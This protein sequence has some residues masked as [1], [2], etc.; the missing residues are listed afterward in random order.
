M[1]EYPQ[2]ITSAEITAAI[3]DKFLEGDTAA[4]HAE[5]AA[6]VAA[7]SS[8]TRTVLA[9]ALREHKT[10]EDIAALIDAVLDEIKAK[11][12]D[13]AGRVCGVTFKPSYAEDGY[14]FSPFVNVFG[15]NGEWFDEIEL[16]NIDELLTAAYGKVGPKARLAI[17]LPA[18]ED[19]FD[20]TTDSPIDWLTAQIKR[21][22][23]THTWTFYGHWEGDDKIVIEYSITGMH[24]D[25]REDTGQWE[26]GLWAASASGHTEQQAECYARAEYAND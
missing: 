15:F 13:D 2:V 9:A 21:Y 19:R 22:A 23:E 7:M 1:R 4:K 24:E 20:D 12:G 14:F 8:D 6:F 25:T 11:L 10:V 16:E 5:I 18:K 17:F 3:V 26:S